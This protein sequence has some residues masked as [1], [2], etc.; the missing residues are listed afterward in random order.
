MALTDS[1]NSPNAQRP[2]SVPPFAGQRPIP[3]EYLARL[4]ALH[5]EAAENLR[6]IGFIGHSA[7]AAG[8]LMLAGAATLLL[9]GGTLPSNFVW[10]LLVLAG[11]AAMTVNHIR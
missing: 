10:S 4:P 2:V 7:G 5:D 1:E 11:V 6:L 3:N 9:G 8:L